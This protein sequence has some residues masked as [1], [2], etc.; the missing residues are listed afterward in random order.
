MTRLK[1]LLAAVVLSS[2]APLFAQGDWIDLFD[3][4][5]LNG[6]E[7]KG[8]A[9]KYTVEDNAIVGVAVPNSPNSFLCT[10][11][12]FANFE[13]ELEFKCDPDLNSGV[14][15]RSECFPEAATA[16]L[17]GKTFEFPAGRVHGYQSEID[18]D[19]KRGRMWTAGIYDEGRR[20]WLFPVEEK[21]EQGQAFSE[22]GRKI[23]KSG[24][25]NKL[26]IVADGPSIKT[27]LND[28]LRADLT[29][30]ATPSGF[31]ALQVHGI[32]ED[33]GKA[34]LE[35]AF[36]NIRLRELPGKNSA[37]TAAEKADG[38]TMLWD[39]RTSAGW[40]SAKSEKF[41]EKGW[42]MHDGVLTV[43]PSGGEESAAGGDIITRKRYANFEFETDFKM[44][45]G[46]NSGIKFFVQPNL[47]PIDKTTGKP[48]A[49]GSAIGLEF[50]ILDDELHPDAKLGKDG[51]R[52]LGSLYDLIP[53]PKDKVQKPIGEW[54]H[55]R[56]LVQGK[57]VVFWLNGRKTVEFE[58]GSE[59]FRK[60]VA[61]SKYHNIPDFG[62]WPDGH[63][64]LQ[65]HG[66]EVSFRN[67]KIRELP[68][69]D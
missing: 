22:Q 24:E 65:D 9:A 15:I 19:A 62:E 39:G 46:A 29:D 66:D 23:T 20:G 33:A 57:H 60:L 8:G 47:S 2:T 58:R 31:I 56:I 21:S 13:L 14:Q 27:W 6:W 36:R 3:G 53:A 40:R 52:R 34:G 1:P 16:T 18:L 30:S 4:K 5:T 17:D 61:G 42:T 28:E 63:I 50:Q 11:R 67:V 45:P 41:P 7:Q 68:A 43:Q 10:T 26:R 64:L 49:V 55:T 48:T 35:A 44:T 32:G 59:D 37:S 12:N 25:W 51:N 38:W 54:N 69:A